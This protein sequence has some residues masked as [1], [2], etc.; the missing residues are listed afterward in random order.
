[1]PI[2][3]YVCRECVYTF[4]EIVRD[5]ETPKCPRCEANDVE[6][7]L[8]AHSYYQI[9]GD[10]TASITPKKFRGGRRE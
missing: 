5:G 6:K 9:K 7:L 1:M 4:E 10:N 3:E 8:S 2:Y